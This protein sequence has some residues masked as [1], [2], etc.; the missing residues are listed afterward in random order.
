MKLLSDVTW[1]QIENFESRAV[2]S[3]K[4]PELLYIGYQCLFSLLTKPR[5]GGPDA[6]RPCG[7]ERSSPGFRESLKPYPWHGQRPGVKEAPWICLKAVKDQ[8]QLRLV[9]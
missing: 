6:R 8:W 7:L 2:T 5:Q 3:T 4:S 9:Q 1:V